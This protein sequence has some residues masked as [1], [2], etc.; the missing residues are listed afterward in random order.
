VITGIWEGATVT[1]VAMQ[2]AYFMGFT[3]V[4]LIGVDHSFKTQ[5][6]AHRLVVSEGADENH[7]H[8][9]YFGKGVRWQLPDLETSERAYM[10]A[11]A[12]FEADGRKVLDATVGG[13]LT[14]F[15]KIPYT[16][17]FRE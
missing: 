5:G 10:K 6:P 14:V 16:G 3:T 17:L 15:E 11:R 12:A 4:I 9:E 7:F 13:K 8:P 2:L 1:Y